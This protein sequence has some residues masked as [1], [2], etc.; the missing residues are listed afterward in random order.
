MPCPDE[1]PCAFEAVLDS[2]LFVTLPKLSAGRGV[3]MFAQPIVLP[4]GEQSY[5]PI[6]RDPSG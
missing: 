2:N 1:L 3:I 4:Q 6:E 5:D